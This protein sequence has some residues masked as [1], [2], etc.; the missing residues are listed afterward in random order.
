MVSGSPGVKDPAARKVRS[1]T[2]DSKARMMVDHGLE[3]FLENWYNGG[4]WKR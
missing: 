3:I 1:A 2:D 4:L